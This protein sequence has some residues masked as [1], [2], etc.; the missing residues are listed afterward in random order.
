MKSGLYACAGASA[1]AS[2]A[3]WAKR[4]D[5]PITKR[6]NV[7]FVFRPGLAD[8]AGPPGRS[9]CPDGSPISA[10]VSCTRR[11]WPVASRTAAR[12]NSRKC[13]SIHSRVKSFGTARTNVSS[14]TSIPFHLAE[15]RPVGGVV[16]GPLEPACDLGPETLCSQLNRLL[17]PRGPG[18]FSTTARAEHSNVKRARQWPFRATGG[19]SRNRLICRV[20][21]HFHIAL[22]R[23]G[24]R[25]SEG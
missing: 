22:H 1:T 10:T 23:C 20:F 21:H 24:Q 12:I 15:P 4:F 9:P 2:A 25:V 3:A 8:L 5:E 6:S 18:S 7:Y 19:R 13:P 16:E 11:W 14:V 17:H